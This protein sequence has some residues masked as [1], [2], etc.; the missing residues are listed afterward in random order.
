MLDSVH[1]LL[2]FIF[3]FYYKGIAFMNFLDTSNNAY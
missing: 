1:K 2:K 3:N